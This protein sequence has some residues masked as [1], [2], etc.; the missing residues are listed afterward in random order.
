MTGRL[1]RNRAFRRWFSSALATARPMK[2]IT[3]LIVALLLFLVSYATKSLQAVDL[4]PV[5]YTTEQPFGGLTA[6]YDDRAEAILHGDGLLGPY[7]PKPSITIA[8]AQAP[9]YSICLSGIY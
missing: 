2:A 7:H 9:G 1:S 4:E 6:L 3:R 8:L 5:M